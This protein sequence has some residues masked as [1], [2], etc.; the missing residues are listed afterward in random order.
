M[1]LKDFYQSIFWQHQIVTIETLHAD[2]FSSVQLI[3]LADGRRWVSKKIAKITW[4]KE[5]EKADI[6][7]SQHIACI[8]DHKLRLTL[9]ALKFNNGYSISFQG[10]L[11]LFIPYC[12]GNVLLNWTKQQS[13]L[14]GR[15][16]AAI[17]QLDLSKANAKAFPFIKFTSNFPNQYTE[18]IEFCNKNLFYQSDQWIVSHRD[19]H[20]LNVVWQNSSQPCLIDWESTGCI[21]P[22][23]ELIGLAVNCANVHQGYFDAILFTAALRGY[24]SECMNLPK[25]DEKLWLL[26]F[27]TWFLWMG[28]CQQQEQLQEV[29][30]IESSLRVLQQQLDQMKDIY[31]A[32]T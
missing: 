5:R 8:V 11:Y 4:L 31:T 3:M 28:F 18:L 16:L 14:L 23:V 24:R 21:H 9:A 19:I 1:Q 6:E 29:M 7:F 10:D 30:K 13:F 27:H 20:H 2:K 25:A 22:F 15:K 17:H 26:C 12:A 32:L